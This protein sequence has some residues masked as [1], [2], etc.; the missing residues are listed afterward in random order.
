MNEVKKKKNNDAYLSLILGLLIG[1]FGTAVSSAILM[2]FGTLLIIL[3]I[4]MYLL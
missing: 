2:F 1:G 4:I 3:G